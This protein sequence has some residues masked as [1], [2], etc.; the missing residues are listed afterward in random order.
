VLG[1]FSTCG[2]IFTSEIDWNNIFD[3]RFRG[4]QP[5]G[6]PIVKRRCMNFGEEV[7]LLPGHKKTPSRIAEHF[8]SFYLGFNPGSI[9][10]F[11][12]T[13]DD[14]N[15]EALFS[16]EDIH[17]DDE[18][19]ITF[20]EMIKPGLLPSCVFG[21]DQ[22]ATYDFYNPLASAR[23]L[24]FGQLSISLNFSDLIKPLEIIPS[25]THY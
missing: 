10:W 23:Q 4:D 17:K 20:V 3:M 5:D 22:S 16:F 15:F 1:G 8:R 6:T 24:G 12:Y 11:V 2:C 7:F 18:N 25:G 9:I 14:N 19:R 21:K 13:D